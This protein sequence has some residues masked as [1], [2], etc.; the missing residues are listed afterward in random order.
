MGGLLL[1]LVQRGSGPFVRAAALLSQHTGVPVLLVAA[2][3]VVASWRFLKSAAKLA[4]EIAIV[5]G[6]LLL[7][8][9]LGW[10]TW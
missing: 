10:L 5:A 3:M 4:A 9:Q 6:A 8:T 1:G 2:A 7:A